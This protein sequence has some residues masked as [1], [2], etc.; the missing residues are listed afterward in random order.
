MRCLGQQHQGLRGILG[1]ADLHAPALQLLRKNGP[2][3]LVVV[4]HQHPNALQHAAVKR[5]HQRGQ[6]HRQDQVNDEFGAQ[7]GGAFNPDTA[8]HQGQQA[9]A[10]GQAQAGATVLACG[11]AV[12]LRK[13]FKNFALRF[14]RNANPGVFHAEPDV[15]LACL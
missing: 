7:T 5:L 13:I 8:T 3:G 15:G 14:R 12:G 11:G 9:L 4:H 2:V 6:R 10:N 1:A